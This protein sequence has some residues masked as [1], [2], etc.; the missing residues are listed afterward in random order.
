MVKFDDTIDALRR[1]IPEL[2]AEYLDPAWI[3]ENLAYPI[4][5]VGGFASFVTK[6]LRSS[7]R[8]EAL[9]ERCFSFIEE[10]SVSIDKDTRDLVY[11]AFLECLGE[12]RLDREFIFLARSYMGPNTEE[13]YEP[14]FDVYSR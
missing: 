6:L 7:E 1:A 14:I 4:Y 5:G 3:E 2:S 12:P 8:D 9:I 11:V 10:L 13:L